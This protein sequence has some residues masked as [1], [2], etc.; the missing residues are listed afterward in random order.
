MKKLNI[1]LL[2]LVS[3]LSI[4]FIRSKNCG[5][6]CGTCEKRTCTKKTCTPKKPCGMCKKKVKRNCGTCKK[7][8]CGC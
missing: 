7:S 4:D 6:S 1:L 5:S 2:L 8:T 3:V